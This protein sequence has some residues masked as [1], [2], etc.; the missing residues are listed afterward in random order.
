M[1][2]IATSLE[3]A[4]HI[5]K[6]QTALHAKSKKSI[7]KVRRA[8]SE[9]TNRRWLLIDTELHVAKLNR[10]LTGWLSGFAGGCARST[11]RQVGALHV[12][13]TSTSIRSWGSSVC[14]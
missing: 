5:A 2:T 7:A 6:L 12:S 4:S 8:I 11:R 1:S 10:L 3:I 14:R 9:L 13:P